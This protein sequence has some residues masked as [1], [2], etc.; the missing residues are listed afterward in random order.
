MRR[1]GQKR[2]QELTRVYQEFVKPGA[3][4]INEVVVWGTLHGLM[5]AATI[6]DTRE[7]QDEWDARLAEVESSLRRPLT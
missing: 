5:P 7:E 4:T 3:F 2:Y 6:R 1:S